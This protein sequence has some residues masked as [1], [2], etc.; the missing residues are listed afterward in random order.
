MDTKSNP[1]LVDISDPEKVREFTEAFLRVGEK[2]APSNVFY[3]VGRAYEELFEK[4]KGNDYNWNKAVEYFNKA[5]KLNPENYH[6]YQARGFILM[7]LGSWHFRLG[8]IDKVKQSYQEAIDNYTKAIELNTKFAQAYNNRGNTRRLMAF[9]T[10]S[11]IEELK[12]ENE[13]IQKYLKEAQV[14]HN[15]AIKL[16]DSNEIFY[17][18]R[19]SNTLH[20]NYLIL[21]AGTDEEKIDEINKGISNDLC[22]AVFLAR[23][24][25]EEDKLKKSLESRYIFS[26]RYIKSKLFEPYLKGDPG[27]SLGWLIK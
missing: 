22:R 26:L 25:G 15:M 17:V 24:K 13:E 4:G 12:E 11:P 2:N 20:L 5:I 14:D 1:C 3:I 23:E 18:N 16:D 7:R 27:D 10:I 9:R 19:A 21:K 6:H 8:N